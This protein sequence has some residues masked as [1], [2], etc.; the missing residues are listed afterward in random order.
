MI[1]KKFCPAAMVLII[2]VG[3]SDEIIRD[4]STLPK[5]NINSLKELGNFLTHLDDNER[6]DIFSQRI[7]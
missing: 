4:D 6:N 7:C 2:D 1:E 5:E 3:T